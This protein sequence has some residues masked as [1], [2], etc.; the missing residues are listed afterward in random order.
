M[1]LCLLGPSHN[2]ALSYNP[3]TVTPNL[4]HLWVSPRL[5]MTLTPS[6]HQ[7]PPRLSMTHSPQ[8]L[9]NPH[10]LRTFVF[11][12]TPMLYVPLMLGVALL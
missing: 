6:P 4:C 12:V 10:T 7:S 9:H 5:P 11:Y 2:L 1:L 8:T 3:L